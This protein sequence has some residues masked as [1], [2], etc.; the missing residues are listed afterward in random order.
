MPKVRDEIEISHSPP[1]AEEYRS[2]MRSVGFRVFPAAVAAESLKRSCHA[3]T[4]RKDGV[5]IGM[6][7]I[8]G[9]GVCFVEIVDVVVDPVHQ[10]KG[11]AKIV[12][13]ALMSYA[14]TQLAEG[15]FVYLSAHVPADWLYAQY[16]FEATAPDAV[17]MCYRVG[18][19]PT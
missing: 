12:M 19:A 2:L 11:L 3:V 18:S 17:G 5:L 16:G 6:G 10:G 13:D 14:T 4:L 7:R 1:S 8:V 9:D 15:A